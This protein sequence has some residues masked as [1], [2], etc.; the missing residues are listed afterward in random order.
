MFFLFVLPWLFVCLLCVVNFSMS[1]SSMSECH[2]FFW[3]FLA[4]RIAWLPI[5]LGN[6]EKTNYFYLITR[7]SMRNIPLGAFIRESH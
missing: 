5:V 1:K 2:Y 4:V 3:N 6:Q 7:D